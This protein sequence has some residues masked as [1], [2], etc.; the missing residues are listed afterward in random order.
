MRIW[1]FRYSFATTTASPPEARPVIVPAAEAVAVMASRPPPVASVSV[2]PRTMPSPGLWLYGVY[3]SS[4]TSMAE[5]VLMVAGRLVVPRLASVLLA[6]S[7]VRKA[8]AAT[9]PA[10]SINK[11]PQRS[12]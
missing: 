5:S 7:K 2:A 10:F 1:K 11:R 4:R 8:P 3:C 12:S 6:G 9:E